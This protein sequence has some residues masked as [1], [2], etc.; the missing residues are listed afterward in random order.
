MT[1]SN[2]SSLTSHIQLDIRRRFISRANS[3]K[4]T[5][6]FLYSLSIASCHSRLLLAPSILTASSHEPGTCI[7]NLV[8]PFLT[9]FDFNLD[10]IQA[11][12]L[13]AWLTHHLIEGWLWTFI[14]TANSA[15]PS[16]SPSLASLR[17]IQLVDLSLH[18]TWTSHPLVVKTF[19]STP[20]LLN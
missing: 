4:A 20:A 8:L 18:L 5:C 6:A 10:M 15:K 19:L 11:H 3:L 13:R 17:E 16:G 12:C 9:I 2:I 14:A 7:P 1:T